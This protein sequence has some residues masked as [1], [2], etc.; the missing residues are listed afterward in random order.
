MCLYITGKKP[1]YEKTPYKLYQ[2]SDSSDL[3]L[4][5]NVVWDLKDGSGLL[6]FDSIKLDSDPNSK[7]KIKIITPPT[8]YSPQNKSSYVTASLNNSIVWIQPILIINNT[9]PT[10]MW[11]DMRGNEINFNNEELQLFSATV[12]Q[13]DATQK[14]GV[15]MGTFIEKKI[16]DKKIQKIEK[17]GLYAFNDKNIVF[18]ITD[19]GEAYIQQSEKAYCLSKNDKYSTPYSIGSKTQPVYF[20]QG[21]PKQIDIDLTNI[22]NKILTL[23]NTINGLQQTVQNLT[24]R[25]ITLE[26]KN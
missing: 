21:V 1:I 11:N 16:V 3:Q 14:N 25:I 24:N 7:N 20:D 10:A 15:L 4:I 9:Y 19:K 22:N 18:K 26:N 8:I 6:K 23:E 2:Y 13:L 5:E 12:G 17:Y